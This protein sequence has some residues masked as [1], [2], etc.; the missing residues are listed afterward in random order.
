[1]IK[2]FQHFKSTHIKYFI[3]AMLSISL[4]LTSC[5]STT[6]IDTNVTAQTVDNSNETIIEDNG[7]LETDNITEDEIT[8]PEPEANSIV[9]ESIE[10]T[11]NTTKEVSELQVHFIDVGQG[12]C[13]LI[14]CYSEAMLIDAGDNDQGTKIQNYLQKQG[15]E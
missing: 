1:M 11:E 15:I 2:K 9:E 6:D 13:T 12:D 7:T 5:G 4:I 3:T 14:I 8:T 10:T